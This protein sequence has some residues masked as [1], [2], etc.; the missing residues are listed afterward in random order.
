[1]LLTFQF[2]TQL[3]QDTSGGDQLAPASAR[4]GCG[5]NT[6]RMRTELCFK[7]QRHAD[8]T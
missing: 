4:M 6:E 3:I 1:M 5:L 8:W 2:D 7:A